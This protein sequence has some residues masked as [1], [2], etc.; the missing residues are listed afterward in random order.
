MNIRLELST[1]NLLIGFNVLMFFVATF[2][3]ILFGNYLDS[4][5]FLGADVYQFILH[6]EVW[7]LLTS[8]FLHANI[9]HL[10][11]NMYALFA[12]GSFYERTFGGRSMFSLYVFA[13][14]GGS[15]MSTLIS[16]VGVVIGLKDPDIYTLGVGASGALFGILG[17]F[18]ISKNVSLDKQRLYS[19]LFLNIF[20]GIIFAGLIDNWAHMGG[21][22]VGLLLGFI[23]NRVSYKKR[24]GLD[25]TLFYSS[26]VL[27]IISF[28][29]LII[30][31]IFQITK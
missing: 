11:V 31:N 6:G 3:G 24:A 22:L 30:Y 27:V 20:I 21:L 17:F 26:L 28:I 8:A 18:I 14:V 12:L 5:D 9:F 10:L 7:R 1:T 16:L 13:G 19:I 4:L 2:F 29:G 15:I 25:N 23:D